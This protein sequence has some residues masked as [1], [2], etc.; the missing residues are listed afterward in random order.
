M[1][2]IGDQRADRRATG[3]VR[4]GTNPKGPAVASGFSHPVFARAYRLLSVG[5]ERAGSAEHRRE[6]LAGLRGRVIEVGAGNGLNFA[7]Y[8]PE[9]SEVV[10]VE[11]EPYLRGRA[12]AAAA[13]A[14][15]P[16]TVVA[17]HAEQLPAPDGAFDAAVAS[18]VLC[19]VP[20]QAA[21]LAELYRVVRAGGELR[22][23]EHVRGERPAAARWQDRL[24]RVWPHLAG[25]CHPNRDTVAAIERAGFRLSWQRRF[26]FQPCV[27]ASPVA[28]HVIGLAERP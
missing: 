13:D 4:N 23:Y 21:A 5:A 2:I 19:S 18:L 15:I 11:P 22:F 16:V 7:H 24:D 1:R 28:P 26:E 20:D 12:S 9:V 17:G 27:L 25:G 3:T 10:A 14:P 8:P 6:A